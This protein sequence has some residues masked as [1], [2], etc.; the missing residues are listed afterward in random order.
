MPS[1]DSPSLDD[2]SISSVHDE[3][4]CL[5]VEWGRPLTLK[6]ELT[7]LLKSSTT[8][9]PILGNLKGCLYSFI[10]ALLQTDCYAALNVLLKASIEQQNNDI[11]VFLKNIS[12]ADYSVSGLWFQSFDYLRQLFRFEFKVHSCLELSYCD[13]FPNC[14]CLD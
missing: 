11:R 8:F 2:C 6:A 7:A 10:Y 13:E 1:L 12:V 4:R 3:L 14:D 9:Y 5:G